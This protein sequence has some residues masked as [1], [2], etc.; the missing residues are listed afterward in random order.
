MG[1]K[2]DTALN[3]LLVSRYRVYVE[4]LDEMDG[5]SVCRECGGQCCRI[6]AAEWQGGTRSADTTAAAQWKGFHAG[7]SGYGV[8]PLYDAERVHAIGDAIYA[9]DLKGRGIDPLRCEYSGAD[10]CLVPRDRLPEHCRAYA[11]NRL[12]ATLRG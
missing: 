3:A 9:A 10:R 5:G 4:G 6:Y 1:R 7:R 12:A 11:C 2:L 8:G